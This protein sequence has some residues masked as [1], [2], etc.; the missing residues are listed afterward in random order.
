MKLNEYQELAARTIPTDKPEQIRKAEFCVAL[1]EE[2]G[3]SVGVIKKT[4]FHNHPFT[5]GK[6]ERLVGELGDTLWHIAA[7]GKEFDISLEEIATY[8]IQKLQKRYP[9]GYS[10]ERSVNRDDK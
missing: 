10:D 3:E 2:A 1:C 7:L 4:V 8:N 9:A 6:R 5:S